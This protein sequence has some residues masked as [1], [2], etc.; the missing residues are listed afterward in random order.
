MTSAYGSTTYIKSNSGVIYSDLGLASD[1]AYDTF[2]ATLQGQVSTL[3]DGYVG[4]DFNLHEEQEVK[5]RGFYSPLLRLPFYPI[6]S[7]DSIVLISGT[8]D[9]DDYFIRPLR[10]TPY[11]SAVVERVN[12][13]WQNKGLY[14]VTYDY[15]YASVPADVGRVA[16]DIAMETLHNLADRYKTNNASSVS[17]GGFSATISNHLE[18]EP[19]HLRK[20]DH[21]KQV[22]FG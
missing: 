10:G 2:I 7:I 5:V 18:R 6:V 17:M 14:T 21:Y 8:I 9:S 20:L 1:S 22:I 13:K 12:G 4:H 3:I 15:G 16:E 11:N 19:M